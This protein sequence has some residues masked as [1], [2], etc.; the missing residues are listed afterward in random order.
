MLL[1]KRG[2]LTESEAKKTFYQILSAVEYCHLHGVAHRDIKPENILLDEFKNIKLGDFGLSNC[3][4]DGEFMKTPCGSANYAAPEIVS[5]QRYAGTEVDVWSLGVLLYTLLAGSLPFDEASMPLLIS[6][7]KEARFRVPYHFSPLATN[8]IEKMIVANPLMRI[9]ISEIFQ[10]PWI[11]E[12]YPLPPICNV[13]EPKIDE[14]IFKQLLKMP[15]F[16]SVDAEE[17]KLK[18]LEAESYDLFT[19]SYEMLNYSKIKSQGMKKN[20]T[21][22]VFKQIKS[23]VNPR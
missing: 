15:Q 22:R 7:I 5:G 13:T 21:K 6:K 14:E 16:N 12:T 11:S 8:L 1:E 4:K 18:I 17:K 20:C 9:S 23:K 19:V 10:H 3:M 2:K